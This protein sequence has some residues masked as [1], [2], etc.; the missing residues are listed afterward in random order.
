M[1]QRRRVYI[2][3]KAYP[4]PSQKHEETVCCAGL[5][6]EG[7]FVRLYPIRYRRLKADARFDRFDL[8]EVEGERPRD[9]HRP[10]SFH[11]DEDS[12]KIVSRG[13]KLKPEAKV[14]LWL[15]LVSQ[16]L[17]V[18]RQANDKEHVSLGIVRPESV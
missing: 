9:D 7:E 6:E 18:L 17:P 11:V 4:Q 2:L 12:I 1:K 8:V 5:T 10:E 15:P 3:V 14:K 16:S 13:A